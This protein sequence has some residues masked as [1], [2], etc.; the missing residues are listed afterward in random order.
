MDKVN[1][2]FQNLFDAVVAAQKAVEDDYI[3]ELRRDYFDDEGHPKMLGMV[4][5]DGK[6]VD[7]PL[8]TLVPHNALKISEVKINFEVD[9]GH[10]EKSGVLGCLGKR[11]ASKMAAVKIKFDGGETPEGLARL[12]DNLVKLIPTV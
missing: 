7:V 8:F 12:G 1:T 6:K 10:D 4:L 2:I 3:A 9:L 11:R 5:G